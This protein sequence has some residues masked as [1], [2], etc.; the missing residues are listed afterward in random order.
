MSNSETIL[1]GSTS[2][3]N[4]TLRNA[5]DGSLRIMTGAT[6]TE[7]MKIPGGG[8]PAFSAYMSGTQ[9]VTTST[10]TKVQCNTEE[11]DTASSY[12]NSTNY[13]FQPTVAGYYQVNGQIYFGAASGMS[14]FIV[15]L[16]KNGATFKSGTEGAPAIATVGR[17][18][19]SALVYLN[20]SSDYIELWGYVSATTPVFGASIATQTYFQAVLVR[21]A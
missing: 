11:F 18:V 9:S 14:R 20:G 2:A 21:A 8:I 7:V 15:E 16:Y 10:W 5:D 12:D 3:T 4:V 1:A 17:G 13:R 19:V 6:P